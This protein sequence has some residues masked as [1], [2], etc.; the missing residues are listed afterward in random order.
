M[1][2]KNEVPIR[3]RAGSQPRSRT[4]TVEKDPTVKK[5]LGGG[6]R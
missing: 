2:R 5:R 4:R 3:K 6:G 1:K